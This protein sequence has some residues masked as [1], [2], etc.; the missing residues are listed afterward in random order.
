[1]REYV[2]DQLV[3]PS[4]PTYRSLIKRVESDGTRRWRRTFILEFLQARRVFIK[5]FLAAAHIASGS[6]LR[7]TE[8][9]HTTFRNIRGTDSNIRD[10]IW[11]R[12]QGQVRITT[13]W[14][15]SR[16]ITQQ[17]RGNIRFLPPNL[18]YILVYYILYTIPVYSYL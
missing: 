6:P 5:L 7:G 3:T 17:S 12:H 16:N 13:Y 10:I 14:Y 18:S 11:D 1:T 4:S 8:W 15:K 9:E 2:L